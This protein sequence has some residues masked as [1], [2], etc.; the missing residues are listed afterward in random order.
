MSRA[1]LTHPRGGPMVGRSRELAELRERFAV[2]ASGAPQVV[3]LGGEA[4]IGK[5]R[6]VAEL[7]GWVDGRAR[8]VVGHCLELGPDGPPFAPIVGVLRDFASELGIEGLAALA[9]PG[10]G[11]LAGLLPELGPARAEDPFGRGRLFEAMATLLERAAAEGP[12]LLVVEDL[13]WS[14]AATRDL[15]RFLT[16][17]VGD[18]AVLVV[19]TY[20]RDELHRSHP[21]LPWLVEMDRLPNAHRVTLERLGDV[22]VEAL[23]RGIAADV[24]PAAVARI[25]QRSQGVP[26]F[27]EELASCAEGGNGIPETLRDV[28]LTR[29][30]RLTPTARQM[31]RIAS[32]ATSRID[33][34]VLRDVVGDEDALDAALREAVGAQVLAVDPE[35]EAYSFRHALMR[36]AV[37]DDLLPGEHARLHARYAEA[38]ERAAGPEQAGEIAHHWWSA[39]EAQRAFTWSLRAAQYSRGIY[40][41]GEQLAHL[42]RALDLWERVPDAAELAGMDHARLLAVAARAAASDGQSDRALALLDASIGELD[43]ATDPGRV[44]HLLVARARVGDSAQRDPSADLDR[45]LALAPEGSRDR[46]AA[47]AT[48]A[49]VHMVEARLEAARTTSLEGLAAAEQIEDLGLQSSL[50]DTLACVLALLGD[51]EAS[52]EHFAAARSLAEASGRTAELVRYYGNHA[53]AL[54][55]QGRLAEAVALAQEGRRLTA[56]HGL[57]RTYGTFLAG[58]EAEAHLLAGQWDEALAVVDEELRM[59]PPPTSRGYLHV[60]RARLLARRGEAD[61]AAEAAEQGADYLA[62]AARQPQQGLPLALARGEVALC[63]GHRGEA[64]QVFEVAA[65]EAG[66]DAPPTV[67][68]PFAWAWARALLEARAAGAGDRAGANGGATAGVV[69]DRAVAP[70]AVPAALV[71][72][73]AQLMATASHPGWC[74]VTEAQDAA[75]AGRTPDW[76]GAVAAI[77]AGEGLRYELVDARLRWAVQLL[78]DGDREAARAQVLQAWEGLHALRADSLLPLAQRV[79]VTARV[80]LPGASEGRAAADGPQALTPREREVLRLVAA[81]RSNGQIAAELFISVKTAS[82]HVSNI[83]AKLEVPSRTAAA[84]WA[85]AH[86]EAVAEGA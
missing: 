55:G 54:M 1:T 31:L 41:F 81:G 52:A 2:A 78:A 40:A 62:R 43:P 65:A 83:L 39:H 85:H 35:A 28:M 71:A 19:L 7:A 72:M 10:R 48:Q 75:L 29:L 42:E 21:L 63:S 38:L 23:V 73:R 15:L 50:H 22:D 25:R 66:L 27:A 64:L 51:H 45:A 86:P 44:A 17:T 13:H 60:V 47:L 34:A 36:E 56:S 11:D 16:R 8:V 24:A 12:L 46:A 79:A 82:V 53:D 26:F 57:R 14:D 49:A 18:A 70:Q 76:A 74:A 5:S 30:E 3:L 77:E 59:A 80:A 6:L 9:G 33:H 84:A 67:G 20:R 68:W 69:A 4:G 37:H 58:N 32:A 61:A